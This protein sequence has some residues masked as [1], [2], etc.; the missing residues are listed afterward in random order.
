MMKVYKIIVFTIIGIT[1]LGLLV[2]ACFFLSYAY[3]LYKDEQ[4]RLNEEFKPEQI[5]GVITYLDKNKEGN[6]FTNFIVRTNSNMSDNFAS[7]ICL[8]GKNEEFGDFVDEGDSVSK[9]PNTFR[10]KVFK[11]K[12]GE[13]KEFD[14]PF[15]NN[16][17]F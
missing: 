4:K 3:T 7:G 6:C 9:I 8:C 1:V 13:D 2:Y 14:F 12:T 11:K 17:W 15:C 5:N 10:I 16:F